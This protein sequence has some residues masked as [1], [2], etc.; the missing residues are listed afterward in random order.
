VVAL[1]GDTVEI[2][3]KQVIVNNGVAKEGCIIYSDSKILPADISP[4]DNFGPFTVPANSYFVL[5]DNRDRSLDSRNFGVVSKANIE[6][7]ARG[8]YWSW[9]KQKSSVRRDRIGKKISRTD[10]RCGRSVNECHLL[11]CP[12][13]LPA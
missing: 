1:G 13:D 9:D 7:K 12:P 6:G 8:I 3:N 4:R 10:D 2:R 11:L 5:G